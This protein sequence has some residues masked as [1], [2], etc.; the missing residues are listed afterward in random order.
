MPESRNTGRNRE[1][2]SPPPSWLDAAFVEAALRRSGQPLARVARVD[3]SYATAVG[4]HY[5]SR[6]Y[7]VEAV[8]RGQERPVSLLVKCMPEDKVILAMVREKGE[9]QTEVS[10]YK[11]LLRAAGLSEPPLSARFFTAATDEVI[12]L[13]DLVAQGFRMGD[14]FA[15]LDF[16]HAAAVLRALG[17]FHAATHVLLEREPRLLEHYR[18]L[19]QSPS[20]DFGGVNRALIRSAAAVARAWADE[21]PGLAARIEAIAESAAEKRKHLTSEA[22]AEFKVLNHGDLWTNNIMFRRDKGEVECRFVDL[23]LCFMSS[24]EEAGW[25]ERWPRLVA[26]YSDALAEAA[27]RLGAAWVPTAED[28]Q[29]ELRR[30][31]AWGLLVATSWVAVI[32]TDAGKQFDFAACRQGGA[33]ALAALSDTYKRRLR[34][35]LPYCDEIGVFEDFPG[36]VRTN[37]IS[38]KHLKIPFLKYPKYF[39]T[40]CEN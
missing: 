21:P 4:D 32:L 15:G 35:L 8:V 7:R 27:R 17:R 28:V 37:R 1:G 10:M 25:R 34:L 38:K 5:C 11:K 30:A 23:Q 16:E 20:K 9:F 26:E 33:A 12:T 19:F 39:N 31:R 14:R 13:E 18:S 29:A 36:I 3:T 40:F 22:Q 24:L 6:M 2:R